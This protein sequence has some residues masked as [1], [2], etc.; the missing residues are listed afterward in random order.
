MEEW[1]IEK[2][3]YFILILLHAI[4]EKRK[5]TDLVI[6]RIAKAIPVYL[7]RK[8]LAWVFKKYEEYD[9]CQK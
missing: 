5:S 8:N 7:L 3:K 9:V 6:K 2:L 4:L 1:Q